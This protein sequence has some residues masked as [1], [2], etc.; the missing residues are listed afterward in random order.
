MYTEDEAKYLKEIYGTDKIG[1]CA[2]CNYRGIND[3]QGIYSRRTQL[4]CGQTSCPMITM[5]KIKRRQEDKE[6][7]SIGN[8]IKKLHL[9]GFNERIVGNWVILTDE[10][11][12]STWINSISGKTVSKVYDR[13]IVLADLIVCVPVWDVKVH[14]GY[15]VVENVE[16]YS[17]RTGDKNLSEEFA[18]NFCHVT[19]SMKTRNTDEYIKHVI[20]NTKEPKTGMMMSIIIHKSGNRIATMYDK[21][22]R[23][24]DIYDKNSYIIELENI[25]GTIIADDKMRVQHTKTGIVAFNI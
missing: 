9:L 11:G 19:Y 5:L 2:H 20:I 24:S 21:D 16:V 18:N 17:I 8:R 4:A 23:I 14:D 12:R 25:R 22:I 10:K 7:K 15:D 1:N 6:N 13:I 3:T